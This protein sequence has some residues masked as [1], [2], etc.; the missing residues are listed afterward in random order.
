MSAQSRIV[1]ARSWIAVCVGMLVTVSHA[2]A[3][4]SLESLRM[5]GDVTFK[6]IKTDF[7]P[8]NNY[9]TYVVTFTNTGNVPLSGPMYLAVENVLPASVSVIWPGSASAEGIP[10]HHIV[11]PVLSPGEKRARVVIFKKPRRNTALTFTPRLYHPV[12]ASHNSP[13]VAN[14]GTDLTAYVSETVVLDGA[15]STDVDGDTLSYRWRFQ[16]VPAGSSAELMESNGLRPGFVVDLPGNYVVELIV[17]DGQAD[18]VPDTIRISTLNSAPTAHAGPDQTVFVGDTVQ[19]DGTGSEDADGDPLGYLWVLAARPEQSAAALDNTFMDRPAFYVDRPGT[20]EID[21]IVDDGNLVSAP[22]RVVITT[23]NSRPVAHAGDDFDA[24]IGDIVVLDGNASSDADNDPL[25]YQWSIV[26]IPANSNAV[27]LGDA[28]ASPT[29]VP[30]L[31][32]TYVV[33]LIVSDGLLESDPDTSQISISVYVP[34]DSDG[35]GLSDEHEYQIGT[36]PNSPDTDGDGLG[37][38]DEVNLHHTDPLDPDSDEDSLSDGDEVNQ[39]LTNPRMADTDG[40]GFNDGAE[41]EAGS[42]PNQQNDTPAG[43]LPPDPASVAPPLDPTVSVSFAD[44]TRFLYTGANPIQTGVIPNIIVT[45]RVAVLR[46]TVTG[47]NGRPLSGVTVTIHDHGEYGQTLTRVDG[48]FDM[49]VNGGGPITVEYNKAGYLG[50]QRTMNAPWQ[51]YAW[52]PDVVMIPIDTRVTEISLAPEAPM[53]VARGSI[54]LDELGSR[55]ATILFPQGTTATMALPD[56]TMHGLEVIHVRATEYTVGQS[57]PAAMPADLPPAS[58]YTYAVE[59]SVDEAISAGAV[60]VNFNQPVSFYVEN[61]RQFP[62]GEIV[63]VGWYDRTRAIWVPSDDGLV[64]EVLGVT[65]GMAD[66][67][68]DGS[69]EPAE[70]AELAG[71]GIT[72]AERVHLGMMYSPG[73]SLFRAPITHFT[74]FD[75][76]FPWGPPPDAINP[77]HEP[78]DI[79]PPDDDQD[80]CAGCDIQPQSQSLGERIPVV[81][82]PYQLYYQSKHMPGYTAKT[83]LQIPVTGATVPGS[84]LPVEVTIQIAGR[85]FRR[86]FQPI[87]HQQYTFVWDGLDVYGRPINSATAHVAIDYLYKLIYMGPYK[88]SRA[89]ARMMT[90]G[91][92]SIVGAYNAGPVRM[93]REWSR[94]LLNTPALISQAGLGGWTLDVHHAYDPAAKSLWLGDGAMLSASDASRIITTAAGG[95]SVAGAGDGG[96]AV[97]ARLSSPFDAVIGPDGSVYIADT[98]SQRIRRVTPDGVITTIAG[99]GAAGFGGDNVP[100]NQAQLSGPAGIALSQE[101]SVYVADTNNHRIRRID[102]NGFITTVAGTGTAGFNGFDGDAGL[103]QLSSPSGVGI[104]TDGVLYIADTGN[105]LIRQLTPDGRLITVA[106]NGANGFQPGEGVPARSVRLN[107]PSAVIPGKDGSF[108]IADRDNHRIRK[109]DVDGNIRTYAG[110]G[111]AGYNGDGMLAVQSQLNEPAKIALAADGGLYI[112]DTDNHRVRMVRSDGFITTIAGTGNIG[113]SGDNGPVAL[114]QLRFPA[115]AALAPDGDLYVVDEGNNRIRKIARASASVSEDQFLVPSA[116]GSQLFQFSV[117]GRHL[118]TLDAVS[119]TVIYRFHYDARG[120]LVGIE[121]VDGDLTAIARDSSG[122]PQRITAPFGQTTEL[123]VDMSGQLQ[124]VIDPAAHS[125]R[126]D[127]A[128]GDLMSAYTDRNGNRTEYAF[129]AD[130]RLRRDVDPVGGG[131]QLHRT[132]STN[133]QIVSMTSGEGRVILFGTEYRPNGIRRQINTGT[134]G[135]VTL[136]DFSDTTQTT[137]AQDGTVSQTVEGPDP[138]FGLLSPRTTQSTITLPQGSVSRTDISRTVRLTDPADLLS[139]GEW[140]ESTTRN[141]R[142][143]IQAY[144][145]ADRTWTSTTP[146]GRIATTVLDPLSRPIEMQAGNLAASSLSY[147]AHGRLTA[148]VQG[149]G[150]GSRTTTFSYHDNGIQAGYL[151]GITDAAGRQNRYRYDAAGRVIE[152]ILPD[153]RVI[154]LSYDTNGNL[155]GITPPGGSAHVFDYTARDEERVYT[156]PDVAAGNTITQYSYNLDR[157]PMRIQ[158]PDG[159]SVDYI[160]DAQSGRLQ[161][162]ATPG[163]SY[164]YGYDIVGR[165]NEITA[166][167]GN[168]LSFDYAGFLPAGQTW[169]GDINGSVSREYNDDFQI[170]SL[171]VN[172][173]SVAYG[174]DDDGLVTTAGALSLSRDIR[175]GLMTGSMLGSVSTANGYNEFGELIS[176]DT[177]GNVALDLTVLGQNITSDILLIRGNFAGA[178]GVAVN[179]VAM[180]VAPNGDVSGE[181]MLPNLGINTVTVDVY[182]GDQLAVQDIAAIDRHA[183]GSPYIVDRVLSVSPSGDVYFFGND[184]NVSGAWVVPAGSGLVQQPAWLAEAADVAVES[185]GNIYLLKGMNI[186]IYDGTG[187]TPVADLASAGLMF[188]NDMEVSSDGAVYV[189]GSTGPGQAAVFRVTGNATL[190]NIPLPRENDAIASA[191]IL[192]SSAWGMI[193]RTDRSYFDRILPDDTA[194]TLFHTS[195]RLRQ[196]GSVGIDDDGTICWTDLAV[197]VNCRQVD[198]TIIAM[199]F[200]ALSLVLGDDGAIYHGDSGGN[201]NRWAAGSAASLIDVTTT[202]VQGELLLSGTLGG[203]VYSVAFIRDILGRITRKSETIEG[204]AILYDY[205]YDMAGRLN[206]VRQDGQITATYSYD[207]NG[208][209]SSGVYDAQDRLLSD[210]TASFTYTANGELLTRTDATGVT[211]Y[212]YDV[213]GN[214]RQVELPDGTGIDYLIDGQNR[215]IGKKVNGDLVQGFLYQDQLNPVAELDESGNVQSRFIYAEKSNVPSYMIKNGTAYRILSDHLGSPRLIVNTEDGS[216]AQRIDYDVWG[217]IMN[218]TNPG[219]QPYGFAGGIHDQQTGLVR[220][221][222][223]DYDPTVGRWTA[224]DPIRFEGGDINLYSY[225]SANPV[226]FIDPMGLYWFRQDGQTPGVVGRPETIVPPYG[227]VSEFIEKYVPAGYTFGQFHDAFVDIATKAGKSDKVVNVPSMIPMYWTAQIIEV[228]RSMGILEQPITSGSS[229]CE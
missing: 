30:D 160:Y 214:L 65:G 1:I 98:G 172:G 140:N 127:Y 174:Y 42:G 14:A 149:E 219:F 91:A 120:R 28:T 6:S 142:T 179:G 153:D 48:A 94:L 26:S 119:G 173:D 84:L 167:D 176:M 62:V 131:W 80:S 216:I 72:E 168:Y 169:S 57:G 89:F 52:L 112:A 83:T 51:D 10:F 185:N 226:M 78:K 228:L 114:A 198:G 217:N 212:N 15:G 59:L 88:G 86:I 220:F 156:P 43:S 199:P 154:H 23:Q 211:T 2:F 192:A 178:S 20:Y 46:G 37:D 123:G 134:D 215:R 35:D 82:T 116:D 166:T 55:Q 74:P 7:N 129:E 207:A 60:R 148:M 122:R 132:A 4:V 141:G 105:G 21:L 17:S 93:R 135:S 197:P 227:M 106:G 115:G 75:C 109:V 225:V 221:G 34:P 44:A 58:A 187:E 85:I 70:V 196:A 25:S 157:Q 181:V 128:P 165:N 27:L 95:G 213:F 170:A 121:D 202:P 222:A 184:G 81:G 40:D 90:E 175:N 69:G 162:I 205:T 177:E 195:T 201:I 152:Q 117:D 209:R 29:F 101:G 151:A 32:G 143:A 164:L 50:V 144:D 210:G 96:S 183:L 56:G 150:A 189:T 193:V 113:L 206:E 203:A 68:L 99:T 125:W 146:A 188:V 22:D 103:I 79:P 138:R 16:S 136:S 200:N 41:V 38:G 49:A 107:R 77:P 223:R 33:Q 47:R 39:H 163:G 12:V 161:A 229:L 18:S 204:S 191:G 124:T 8:F 71:L 9:E 66:I 147:D 104:G 64:I 31:A 224:R 97:S 36:D 133:N 182:D 45:E 87:P 171:D 53:Q 19:L 11:D 108:Y 190:V 102:T 61:V 24:Y 13:P 3:A 126:M 92:V 100:A 158:R 67:D 5:P 111:T 130:G 180:T 110:T 145:A 194:I 159:Q 139:L 186:S 73:T 118:R 218:D 76:N 137:T 54:S 208:N 155:T 63:P